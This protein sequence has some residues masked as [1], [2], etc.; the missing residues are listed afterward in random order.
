[1]N[2][3]PID[4]RCT[5]GLVGLRILCSEYQFNDS[6]DISLRSDRVIKLM[7]NLLNPSDLIV[8]E[9]FVNVTTVG[10]GLILQTYN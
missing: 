5:K 6:T 4:K 1:M 2:A 10:L 9:F 8:C 3:R 7:W